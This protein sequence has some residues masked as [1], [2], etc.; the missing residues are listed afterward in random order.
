[1]LIDEASVRDSEMSVEKFSMSKTSNQF[2]ISEITFK[3]SSFELVD[4]D[5]LN[6]A[7]DSLNH[8][9]NSTHANT[10]VAVEISKNKIFFSLSRKDQNLSKEINI[11]SRKNSFLCSSISKISNDFLKIENASLNVLTSKDINSRINEVNIIHEKKVR[12]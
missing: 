6:Q 3:S 9:E 5:S 1:V 8:S 10:F 4:S 7:E 12:K 2:S 11:F